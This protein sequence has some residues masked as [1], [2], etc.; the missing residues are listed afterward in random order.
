MSH[1]ADAST[2]PVTWWKASASGA[3]SD[4]VECAI[5]DPARVAVRDSKAP[6]GPALLLA[7]ASLSALVAGIK[8][9]AL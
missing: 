5:V 8:T 3:Q 2:L 7:R 9:G 4:C 6:T 1:V